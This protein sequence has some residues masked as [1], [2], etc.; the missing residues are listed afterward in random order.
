[1]LLRKKTEK[2]SCQ[3]VFQ[4]KYKTTE[5]QK[6]KTTLQQIDRMVVLQNCVAAEW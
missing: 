3:S 5:K 4:Y 6:S 1:M 2:H